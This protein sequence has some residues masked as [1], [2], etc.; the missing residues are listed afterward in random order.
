MAL[1]A[2]DSD[3]ENNNIMNN[4]NNGNVDLTTMR[5]RAAKQ[6]IGAIEALLKLKQRMSVFDSLSLIY[7]QTIMTVIACRLTLFLFCV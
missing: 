5:E 1:Q 2:A 3:N 6:Y 7:E 4:N